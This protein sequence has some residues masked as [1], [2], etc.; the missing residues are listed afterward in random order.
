[1][2]LTDIG[3]LIYLCNF[4]DELTMLWVAVIVYFY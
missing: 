4:A 1:M 2:S 3:L